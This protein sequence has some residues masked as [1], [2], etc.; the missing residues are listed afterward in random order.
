V[1]LI[2]FSDHKENFGITCKCKHLFGWL[3]KGKV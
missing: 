2:E 3:V 1:P